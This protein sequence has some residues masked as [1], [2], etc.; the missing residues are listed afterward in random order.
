MPKAFE[1]LGSDPV[2]GL[3]A[4]QGFESAAGTPKGKQAF[5]QKGD[6]EGIGYSAITDDDSLTISFAE[7]ATPVEWTKPQDIPFTPGKTPALGVEGK[8]AL[9]ATVYGMNAYSPTNFKGVDLTPYIT[10]D[11]GE[12]PPPIVEVPPFIVEV[13]PLPP[14]ISEPNAK[15][16]KRS[17]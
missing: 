12:K 16:G 7:S 2:K 6:T 10:I 4:I 9:M 13:P 14:G 15:P 8:G 17:L 3:T 5:F 11:G 1:T